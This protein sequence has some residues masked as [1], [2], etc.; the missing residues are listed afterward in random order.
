MP[1]DR[2][3]T[4]KIN[5]LFS[6]THPPQ[7]LEFAV[8]GQWRKKQLA[9]KEKKQEAKKRSKCASAKHVVLVRQAS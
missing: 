6:K 4:Y 8:E 5:A 2:S 9:E 3:C 1:I 7:Q